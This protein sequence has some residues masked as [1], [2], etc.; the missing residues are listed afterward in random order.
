MKRLVTAVVAVMAI[1]AV[2]VMANNLTG[3]ASTRAARAILVVTAARVD[4]VARML[5]P[6]GS[7]LAESTAGRFDRVVDLGASGSAAPL[8]VI[9]FL[10]NRSSREVVG[11]AT[12]PLAAIQRG[13]GGAAQ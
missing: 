1:G 8:R 13:A 11:V 4:A 2:T 3:R 12:A 7:L 5:G 9:A 10:Q 6:I